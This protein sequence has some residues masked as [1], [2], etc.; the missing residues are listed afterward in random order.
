MFRIL[1]RWFIVCYLWAWLVLTS[2]AQSLIVGIPS[3][4]VAEPHHLEITH[5]SQWNFWENGLKWN[6]FNFA[7]YGI[8]HNT[9]ITSALNNLNNEG[10]T[11]LALGLGAKKVFP[12]FGTYE[13]LKEIKLTVGSNLLF[14]ERKREFGIWIYGHVSGRIPA[15]RTRL[16]VGG[17]YGT[18]QAFG[19]RRLLL[20]N[21]DMALDPRDPASLM[22]G[23]EQ[24]ITHRVSI[25]GDW[26][27]G[28]HDLAAFIPALQV[29]V[30]KHVLIF[31]Y[32][33]PHPQTGSQALILECM[34]SIPLKKQH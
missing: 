2:C 16:T 8:G 7:C 9:E 13:K 5:E 10:S 6:S 14:S 31:G 24:P 20:A 21:G 15:T 12:L 22:L 28:I 26:F 27:S 3:A 17:S 34:F 11:N 4:D 30:K 33:F 18:Y 32:K 23:F 19:F 1:V 29:D 25:I